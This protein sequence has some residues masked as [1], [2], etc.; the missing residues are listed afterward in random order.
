ME[1]TW[2]K[3]NGGQ[4]ANWNNEQTNIWKKQTKKPSKQTEVYLIFI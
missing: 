1:V 3:K 4:N 2:E